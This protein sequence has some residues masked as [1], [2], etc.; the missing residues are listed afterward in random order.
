M[1][2][3]HSICV[4]T[5]GAIAHVAQN[6][7]STAAD[8]AGWR[9]NEDHRRPVFVEVEWDGEGEYPGADKIARVPAGEKLTVNQRRKID[10]HYQALAAILKNPKPT[11]EQLSKWLDPKWADV[12]GRL[13]IT[14][15]PEGVKE[16]PGELVIPKGATLT[17]NALTK[18]GYVDVEQGATL[19][20]NALTEVSGSVYVKQ[21]ATL[22]ANALTKVGSVYVEQGAT[23]TANALTKVGY[24]DVKQGATLTAN[25]LTEVS[26]SVYVKQGATLTA[27]ALKKG[28]AK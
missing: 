22:T 15:M 7:H 4:R 28:G 2:D 17:A 18:V 3:F 21:G 23:L 27:P 8:A 14:E 20:A 26:G 19:T 5:D 12:L 10:F 25:A 9:N 13:R 11:F 1:C 6:S 16:W 24:V